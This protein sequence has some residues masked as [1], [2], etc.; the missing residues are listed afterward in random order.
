MT[1]QVVCAWCGKPKNVETIDPDLPISHGIHKE[2]I[3]KMKGESFIEP[4]LEVK[5]VLG[6]EAVVP[7]YG[8]G[9][10]TNILANGDIEV[11]PYV[12]GYPMTF[13]KKN[14]MLIKLQ[15]VKE[16]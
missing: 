14:V 11:T 3:P 7:C 9:R 10:I 1:M 15:T 13:D 4:V 2:C 5:P 8:I 6:Q 16:K 12:C